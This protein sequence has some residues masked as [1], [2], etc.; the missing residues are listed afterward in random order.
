MSNYNPAKGFLDAIKGFS[1]RYSRAYVAGITPPFGMGG[2]YGLLRIPAKYYLE[3]RDATGIIFTTA[4]PIDPSNVQIGRANPIRLTHTLTGTFREISQHKEHQITISGRT[5]LDSRG[6]YN[7]DGGVMFQD[8][9]TIFKEFDEM[10]K[11][12]VETAA[13]E[14]GQTSNLRTRDAYRVVDGSM[15]ITGGTGP[16][17]LHM[18]LR[19]IDEDAHFIVEPMAF[20]YGRDAN[21]N[22]FD[23]QYSIQFK[24]YDFAYLT[25]DY[26]AIL[27][28]LDGVDS[29]VGAALGY[30]QLLDNAVNNVSNDYVDGF[31]DSI[32]Q[33]KD[34][35]KVIANLMNSTGG[36]LTNIGGIV[37]DFNEVID[38]FRSGG[39]INSS[40]E[41]L[42]ASAGLLG[43]SL[44][45]TAEEVAAED[46]NAYPQNQA[47]LEIQKQ[48]IV[49]H[50]EADIEPPEPE[51]EQEF[52]E[53]ANFTAISNIIK[54]TSQIARKSVDRNY[55]EN[56]RRNKAGNKYVLGEYLSNE[57]NLSA[58]TKGAG[59]SA[60]GTGFSKNVP[61]YVHTLQKDDDLRRI[62]LKYFQTD[63]VAEEIKDLNGWR[64]FRRMANGNFPEIGDK[65]YI[66]LEGM[67]K[68][69][70]PFA[71]L[72]DYHSTD[73][74]CEIDDLE[75]NN[76]SGDI[77]LV[78][79]RENIKQTIKN[80]LFTNEGDVCLYPSFGV[81][82]VT[83]DD[84]VYAAAVIREAV[85]ANPRIVDVNNIVI[86]Q[87]DDRLVITMNV[88]LVDNDTMQ[89][90][91]PIPG[92]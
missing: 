13:L 10:L 48:A 23:F 65:I 31:R 8:A 6:G 76:I 50:K 90:T 60:A 37:S 18:V 26:P 82:N 69:M 21:T 44:G 88:K 62:S 1:S 49:T 71:P 53:F 16:G 75:F 83:I 74:Q 14:F 4:F 32:S 54:N 3:V 30:V 39:P 9:I 36:L 66:P 20:N 33:I 63:T 91:A 78:G 19:C 38:T 92:A 68:R 2:A 27:G 80:I 42:Q 12:Y 52:H 5:G 43:A 11:H 87:V 57:S 64:D 45:L 51:S 7:R 85:I 35:S 61:R 40:I 84:P 73:I 34:V 79:G 55:F 17:G 28:V 72:G 86:E 89:V 22:R 29:T 59:I 67:Q 46:A 81:K 24:A 58:L 47:I 56:R 70:N 41:N 77:E 15:N 25:K